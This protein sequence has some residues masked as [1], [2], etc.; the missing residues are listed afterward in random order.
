MKFSLL[1]ENL[2]KN[3][4]FVNRAVSVKSQSP[5]LGN[6][7]LE[8]KKGKL[9]ISATDLEIGIRIEVP[10]NIE[11]EGGVMIPAKIF[12]DFISSIPTG[13]TSFEL[14]ENNLK[15]TAGKA[16]SN[17]QTSNKEEFPKL[18]DE[19][20]EKLF[21][22]K[23]ENLE[24]DF[25]SVVFAASTDIGRPALSGVLIKGDTGNKAEIVATDGYRL[26]L[27]QLNK[28]FSTSS[29]LIPARIIKELLTNKN[30]EDIAVFISKKNNQIIF[31]QEGIIIVGRLIDAE[32]PNYEKIIPQDFEV[33]VWFNKNELYEAVKL[34]SIFARDSAN[35]IK[36]SILK[37]SISVSANAPSVGEN[38]SEVEAKVE[39]EEN[40]IAF[41]ARYLLDLLGTI[42]EEEMVF[43]MTGPLSPGV[44]KLKNDPTFLHLIMPIRVQ[45][46]V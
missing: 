38:V 28:D 22:I 20:G 17:F 26:S 7:L 15:V 18:F 30:E 25:T 2:Q 12:T 32:F 36:L 24:K 10:A 14:I 16:K 27:K 1:S 43:E 23:K 11:K 46:E 4:S 19:K 41:N 45:E 44:F 31:E 6:F 40:Q 34:S 29:F 35:I 39:G 21:E 37:N 33:K 5:I 42:D 9:T 3:L 8:A 13:K